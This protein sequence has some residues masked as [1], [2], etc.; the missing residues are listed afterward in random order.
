MNEEIFH[1]ICDFLEVPIFIINVEAAG[2]F[3]FSYLNPAFEKATGLGQEGVVGRRF[4]DISGFPGEGAAL[5]RVRCQRCLEEGTPSGDGDEERPVP[6]GRQS[7]STVLVPMRGAAGKTGHIAGML[8]TSAKRR[9]AEK[10]LRQS[11]DLLRAIIEAVPTAIIGLDLDGNVHTVWNAA[12]EKMLGW[13]AQEVMGRPLPTVPAGSQEEFRGFRES[14]RRGLTLNGVEVRRQKRDGTPID[15]SIYASPLHDAEGH[16]SGNIAVLVDIGERKRAKQ[17]L[18]ESENKMRSILENIGI[19]VSLISPG[20]E[21]LEMNRQMREWFPNVELSQHPV[22]YQVFN[23]PPGEGV[24]DY[25]PTRKTFQDGLVHKA[26]TTTPQGDRVR[27]Y[28]VVSSP[29]FNAS[30]EVTAVIEMVED[31]TEQE[32]ADKETARLQA[33]LAQAQKMES[34]GR[35]AGGVAH[36]FNNM[37]SVIIGYTELALMDIAPADPRYPH[38]QEV[39]AAARRSASFTRQLLAFARRQTVSPRILNLNDT[40]AGMLNMLERLIGENIKLSWVPAVDLWPVKM[41]SSQIDQVLTNLCVNARDAISGAGKVTITTG[42]CT[43]DDAYCASH[44]GLVPGDYTLLSV[45][46]DGYGM[47]EET[48]SHIFEPFFSTKDLKKGTGLGLATV[49]GIV[50]QNNG[51][52]D[53]FSKPGQGTAFKVYF[54]RQ[55]AHRVEA[56]GKPEAEISIQ[57]TETILVVDDENVVLN[58][59]AHILQVLGYTPLMA[60]SPQE[61]M[62]LFEKHAQDIQLLLTDVVLPEM[63]GRDLAQRLV[64]VKPGLKCLYMSGYAPHIIAPRGVLEK[65][66]HFIPKPISMKDL[67]VAVRQVLDETPSGDNEEAG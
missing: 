33:Q 66:I 65:G 58:L 49:Y 28:H 50:K 14:I 41:D 37:L 35:L 60:K 19:G 25:C 3:T 30:K 21:I 55:K 52:I 20:M 56:G 31:I 17:A 8:R 29:I 5:L 32:Q 1:D 39:V 61:A 42:N 51:Y 54:P 59:C 4:E 53:V 23:N 9:Q 11:H 26:T 2:C 15:Y 67:G 22:C 38:L 34:V 64:S 45:T 48:Q 36:D 27:H 62:C 47:D 7:F 18:E 16:I 43:F 10:D 12:A 24:C 6:M 63:T 57:G 44:K 40:V 13:S 46:D